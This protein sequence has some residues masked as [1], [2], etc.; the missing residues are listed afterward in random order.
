MRLLLDTHIL[1]WAVADP[2][3]LEPRISGTIADAQ[4]ELW[5]SPISAWEIALLAERGRLTL[6]P[7]VGRWTEEAVAQLALR[8]APL[9][10]S[11]ALESRRLDVPTSDPADRFIAATARVYDCTL[12][13][14]DPDLK[15]VDG[16]PVLFNR[17]PRN[18][19]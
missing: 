16:L 9:T 2:S 12:V 8:E 14:A 15:G 13:T 7:D 18:R 11:V 6:S 1:V 19:R 3:R 4:H 17:V 10:L 5:L